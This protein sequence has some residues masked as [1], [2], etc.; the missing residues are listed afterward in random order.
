MSE[1]RGQQPVADIR[2][3]RWRIAGGGWVGNVR[4]LGPGLISAAS[5]V[6][7]TTVATL[8]I[9]GAATVYGLSWLVVLIYFMLA[10]IQII[11]A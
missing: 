9:L 1:D 8:A 7:P 11:S 3:G 2:S 4:S 10:S 5:D 6:D